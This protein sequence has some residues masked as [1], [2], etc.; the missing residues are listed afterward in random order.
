MQVRAASRILRAVFAIVLVGLI[1]ATSGCALPM[2]V[3]W[4]PEAGS[5][6]QLELR[7]ADGNRI[8]RDGLLFMERHHM[9]IL[10]LIWYD[11]GETA[12][13]VEIKE[14]RAQLPKEWVVAVA[15]VFW[16]PP[17]PPMLG[18]LP[19]KNVVVEPYIPGYYGTKIYEFDD[20]CSGSLVVASSEGA[21][22]HAINDWEVG[23]TGLTNE[24]TRPPLNDRDFDRLKSHIEQ[25]VE[26][27]RQSPN[28]RRIQEF[29]EIVAKQAV[30]EQYP[31]FAYEEYEASRWMPG[32]WLVVFI[33]PPGSFKDRRLL[34]VTDNGEVSE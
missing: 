32:K 20:F 28:E 26:R 31:E 6:M 30:A 23:L 29:V 18:V 2:L 11:G 14:G 21:E 25:E 16:T 24:P 12:H 34:V 10:G 7:D 9:A 27:L 8:D 15:G 19:G 13:V 22:A 33:K 4:A 1:S 17:F 5:G 3:F